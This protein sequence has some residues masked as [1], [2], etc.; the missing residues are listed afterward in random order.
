MKMVDG[1]YR[2]AFNGQFATET[3]TQIIVG[4]DAS[5]A[6]SD[7]GSW[8]PMVE[9]PWGATG[10][11][12]RMGTEAAKAIYKERAATSECVSALA[13]PGGDSLASSESRPGGLQLETV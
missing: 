6:G 9:Q 7:L 8:P 1:G 3:V 5:N 2:P 12:H 11:R 10:G 13:G 4:V